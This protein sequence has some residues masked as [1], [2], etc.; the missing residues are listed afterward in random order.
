LLKNIQTITNHFMTD[1]HPVRLFSR[2]IISKFEIGNYSWRVNQGCVKRP[3]YGYC[4][5][6]AAVLAKSLGIKRISILEFGVAGGI[7]LVNLEYHAKEISR[8]LEID[9]DIYGFDSGE[10]LPEPVDYRD[11]PY[12][13]KKGFFKMDIRKLQLK[14]E[15]AKLVLGDINE[16]SKSFFTK[17]SP[18]PIGAILYDFDYY[19]STRVALKMLEA[20]EDYYLPRIFCYF[21][22]IIGTEIEL[23]NDFTGERLAINEFNDTHENVK[24]AYP[25]HLIKKTA[26]MPWYNQIRIGHFFKHSRYNEFISMKNQQ[27]HL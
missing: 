1:P 2:I 3:Y 6:N 24:L 9:I 11:L 12:H 5:Y 17:Y 19:S 16:T 14:L 20:G 7:G 26:I 25:Y 15:K 18:A 4:A 27:L 21:D 23:Y 22:D 10:G 8:M 13:W